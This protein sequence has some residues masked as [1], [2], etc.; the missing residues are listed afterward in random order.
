MLT[1]K[2]VIM[3][4]LKYDLINEKIFEDDVLSD[5]FIHSS[6]VAECFGVGNATIKVMYE[7]GTLHGFDINGELYFP[8][9]ILDMKGDAKVDKK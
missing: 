4:I 5:V 7:M 6:K 3:F 8:K 2:D 1:G 9:A